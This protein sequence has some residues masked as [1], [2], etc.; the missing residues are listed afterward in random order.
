MAEDFIDHAEELPDAPMLSAPPPPPHEV[1]VEKGE[2][3]MHD[4]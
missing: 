4:L 2:G 1:L 3:E